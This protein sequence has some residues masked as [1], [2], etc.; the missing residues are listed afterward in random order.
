MTY[1]FEQPTPPFLSSSTPG[2]CLFVKP[3]VRLITFVWEVRLCVCVCVC[4]CVWMCVC[5]H[6][7]VI[8]NYSQF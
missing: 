6:P 4:V 3:G 5:P 1:L 2:L 7:Q 8:R